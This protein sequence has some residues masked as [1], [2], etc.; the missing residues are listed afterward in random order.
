MECDVTAKHI[1]CLAGKKSI[2]I[3]ICNIRYCPPKIF[4][5]FLLIFCKNITDIFL[6][7]DD[8]NLFLPQNY[9]FDNSS[10]HCTSSLYYGQC[11]EWGAMYGDSFS[12]TWNL[13]V[14]KYNLLDNFYG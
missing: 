14:P 4:I 1:L 12:N 5:I 7:N 3:N 6:K 11:F 8:K 9:L 2:K 10:K 13:P